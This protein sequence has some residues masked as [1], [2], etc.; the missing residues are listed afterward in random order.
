VS[1][2]TPLRD[3]V[4]LTRGASYKGAL[5]GAP[6][7]ALLGLGTIA[8]EGGFRPENVKP[9]GGPTPE[10]ILLTA[11]DLYVSL[12][13]ITHKAEL[14]GAV[15]QVPAGIDAARLTQDTIRL[16]LT[17]DIDRTYLYWALREPRYR[18]Y[19]KSKGTGTTNLD[20]SPQDFLSYEVR[21]PSRSDQ[22]GIAEV[23]GALDD[24]IAANG[25]SV[26]LALDLADTQFAQQV[27]AAVPGHT[28]GELATVGGG[29]TPRT[30]N[31]DYWN[32]DVSWATPTDIT[33]LSA[34]YLT[35]T[36][37]L[38]SDEGLANCSSSLY[39]AGSILMTS[40]ATIGAFA[41]AQK[42]TAVNQGFIVVNANDPALQMW[43]FH[44]MRVR[45]PEFI[46]HANG[47]TFLE[48][49]RGKFKAFPVRVA[50]AQVMA[51]FGAFA[52][53]LHEQAAAAS[54]ESAQLATTRDALLPLLMS[55]KVTVKDAESVVGEVL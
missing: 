26:N 37:R 31:E 21:T 42:P 46:S 19:C 43:L 23:V 20:L 32:G 27:R 40:R 6:G 13:D 11:G 44:E 38:I 17:G 7:P 33:A 52:K 14:L 39:P 8:R 25:R 54:L 29:G 30:S 45:V 15:A 41:L 48:L 4:T 47:A 35:T 12:K 55:G 10:R 34:P 3:L 5:V 28:F 22:R 49:S 36:A 50:D 18:A 2:L 1:E 9:Y 53:A 16:D 51:D 24:K